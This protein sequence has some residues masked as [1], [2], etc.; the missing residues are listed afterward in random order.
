LILVLVVALYS[1]LAQ[2]SSP[3]QG[4]SAELLED[5]ELEKRVSALIKKAKEEIWVGT[6]SFKAG[7]HR[8][9]APDRLLREIVNAHRRGLKVHVLLERPEDPRSDLARENERSANL[10]RKGAVPVY[11]DRPDRRSHMKV[12][13]VDKRFVIIGSH[14]LTASA[15]RHNREL[16]VLSDSPCLADRTIRYLLDILREAGVT[17]SR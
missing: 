1:G 16:S 7:G 2:A 4:V 14:N 6:F 13:V 10:L 12:V 5:D 3:C 9:S 8:N 11:W 15:L 17:P